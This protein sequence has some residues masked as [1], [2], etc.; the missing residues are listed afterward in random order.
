MNMPVFEHTVA[1]L[2]EFIRDENESLQ[3]V[4]ELIKYDPGLYFSLLKHINSSGKRSEVTSISQAISLIGAQ[5]LEKFIIRQENFVNKDYLLLW[6]YSAVAG[7]TAKLINEMVGIANDDE[8]FFTGILSSLGMIMILAAHPR[9]RKIVDLLLKLPAEQRI[10]I[11]EGLF[12][13]NH[14]EQLHINLTSPEIYRDIVDCMMKIFSKTGQRNKFTESPSKLS[15]AYKSFQMFRLADISEAA[16]RA[17]LFPAV[18]E[19]QDKFRE[20]AKTYF[21][22]AE[23]EIEELLAEVISRFDAACKTF[24]MDSLYEQCTQNAAAY[25]MP[26]YNFVTRS[27]AFARTVEAVYSA[28]TEGRNIF[29]HGESSVGKRL[30]ALSLHRRPDCPRSNKPLLS[31]NCAA[32]DGDT[33]DM[34]MCGERGCLLWVSRHKGA[35]EMAEG[36]TLLLTDIDMLTVMQQE[37]LA[38]L[39]SGDRLHKPGDAQ[40]PVPDI[41][42]FITSRKDI[43]TEAKEGRF[44]GSLLKVINPVSMYLPPLRE[45][46]EDIDFIADAIIKKYELNI[47]D[48][49]LKL[50]L[51]ECYE[52]QPFNDNLR[53]L[54]R[55]L[56]FITAKHRL[57]A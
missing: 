41:Q 50:G 49:A 45:R 43:F 42:L 37:N 13:T 10:F 8:A 7:E 2:R 32:L 18:V 39:L 28:N 9:Y 6:C 14:I 12:K 52:T 20:L 25:V 11:E 21:K 3:K 23:N 36:G 30:L 34:E 17:V 33:F 15:I 38:K 5:G 26:A 29:V 16:A 48:P 51:R 56:F 31:L 46:R 55:L 35:L 54:K 53:D 22:I 24:K 4:S 27:E 47:D 40:P 44:S 1:S 19:A 57:K